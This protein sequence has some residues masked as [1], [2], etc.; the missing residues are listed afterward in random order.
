MERLYRELMAEDF[1][2]LAVGPDES[3]KVAARFRANWSR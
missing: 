2:I 1:V 3:P